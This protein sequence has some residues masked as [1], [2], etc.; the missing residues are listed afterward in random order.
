MVHHSPQKATRSIRERYVEGE[1]KLKLDQ[2]IPY[3]TLL[4]EFT[5]ISQNKTGIHI[6]GISIKKRPKASVGMNEVSDKNRD[7]NQTMEPD[8]VLR[9]GFLHEVSARKSDEHF[10]HH[11]QGR[12]DAQ[13]GGG[14]EISKAIGLDVGMDP[15]Q[16]YDEIAG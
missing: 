9:S 3:L 1:H 2:S 15:D 16:D 10:G 8:P 4:T 6:I 14:A 12:N 13:F 11:E 7:R 5:T